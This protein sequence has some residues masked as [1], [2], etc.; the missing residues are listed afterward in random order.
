MYVHYNQGILKND[1]FI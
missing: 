1:N